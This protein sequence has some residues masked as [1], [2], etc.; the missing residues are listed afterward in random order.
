MDHIIEVPGDDSVSRDLARSS[1]DIDDNVLI[2]ENVSRKKKAMDE[3]MLDLSAMMEALPS[4]RPLY[5]SYFEVIDGDQKDGELLLRPVEE[6]RYPIVFT[7]ITKYLKWT[8]PTPYGVKSAD[9]DVVLGISAKSMNL[10][11]IEA[12]VITVFHNNGDS[13]AAKSE[14][15]TSQEL[16]RLCLAA[17]TSGA[18]N[19][20]SDD[21]CFRW[22]LH[23]KLLLL[24]RKEEVE[25][26]D[27]STMIVMEVKTWL[28][29]L[30]DYGSIEFH[31]VEIISDLKALGNSDPM[32]KEHRPFI[33][34]ADINRTGVSPLDRTA[35]GLMRITDYTISRDETRVLVAAVAG[36]SQFLQLW[37]FPQ[38]RQQQLVAWMQFRM[39]NK[40]AYDYCLSWSGSQLVC[41]DLNGLN[42]GSNKE[43]TTAF[44]KVDISHTMAPD[45]AIAGSGF[46]SFTPD[47]KDCPKLKDL[48]AKAAFHI[49][50]T[51]IFNHD[52]LFVTCD[53]VTIEMYSTQNSWK[54]LRSIVIGPTR[55]APTP[56]NNV[57]NALRNNLR[58]SYLAMRDH[59]THQASTWDIGRG[60]RSSSYTNLTYEQMENVN[61]CAAVSK[62]GSRIAITGKYK[63]DIFL[64]K[65]WTLVANYPF[66]GMEYHPF[67]RSVQ[68]IDNE[69]IMV[70]LD[71]QHLPLYKQNRGLVLSANRVSKVEEYITEGRDTFRTTS[72][73]S[74]AIC[75]GVSQVSLFN[76]EDRIVL[77]PRRLKKR[78]GE[79]CR[80]IESFLGAG[81]SEPTAPSGLGFKAEYSTAPIDIHGRHEDLPVLVVT[82]K[83]GND[84]RRLSISL[85]KVLGFKSASFVNEGSHLLISFS[86]LVM[87]WS[88]PSSPQDTFTLQL[89]H[90][91]PNPSEWKVCSH[92]QLYGLRSEDQTV[93]DGINLNDPVFSM[94]DNFMDGITQLPLIFSNSN[95]VVQQEIIHYIGK[96]VNNSHCDVVRHVC[97]K[98]VEHTHISTVQLWKAVLAHPI[99]RWIPKPD[100]DRGTNPLV[101]ILENSVGNLQA[102][103]LAE[104]FIEYCVH[105]VK[106]EKDPLFLLPILQCLHELADPK[107]PHYD[108]AL[109]LLRDLAYLPARDR[110]LIMSRHSIAH[111]F[112]LRLRFWEPNSK[113][114][115]QYKD[116]VLQV[117]SASTVKCPENTFSREIYLASSEMLWQGSDVNEDLARKIKRVDIALF[118][119][120]LDVGLYHLSS[121][122]LPSED[123]HEVIRSGGTLLFDETTD[124]IEDI[125]M[126]WINFIVG[127]LGFF[128][129]IIYFIIYAV[130]VT[131]LF[132]F[133]RS[134][135]ACIVLMMDRFGMA[136]FPRVKCHHFE[137]EALNNPAIAAL[138]EYKW[139]TIGLQYWLFRFLAQCIYYALV[140]AGIFMQIYHNNDESTMRSIFAAI[141]ALAAWFLWLELLQIIN[142]KHGYFRSVYNYVDLLAFLTPFV[143]SILQ[144][145]S[146]DF[147]AQNSL[148]SFSALFIFLH[149]S[150]RYDPVSNGLS[151]DDV[152]IHIMLMMFFFFTVIVMMNV[153][154]AL[155]NHA[156]DDGE[157]TWELDW[158]QNRMRFVESAQNMSYV[159]EEQGEVDAN[160]GDSKT[161]TEKFEQLQKKQ[162]ETL[163]EQQEAYKVLLA[164]YEEQKRELALFKGEQQQ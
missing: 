145:N 97:S 10:D 164:A 4:P 64:T 158:L 116:Q 7:A 52:Q 73:S 140:I 93:T 36:D 34:T 47:E 95:H 137:F 60:I 127:V 132:I 124:L 25:K 100:M 91:V 44:Y 118:Q 159:L 121:L 5:R 9:Y 22:K 111:P 35:D 136:L 2:L 53:G 155:I 87:V 69:E 3:E 23:E 92:R 49:V 110:E 33:H 83:D 138:V 149:F 55:D 125:D 50:D 107:K 41:V 6:T 134:S 104:V 21:G 70:A 29:E 123:L 99:V 74:Q 148:L 161:M 40:P 133:Y 146:A 76:L 28:G 75:I 117:T 153:L 89:V 120:A 72:T 32:Y 122:F 80:S 106:L 68:F 94:E 147:G 103:K 90:A 131:I 12:I 102:F 151:N 141:V 27:K 115:D 14:V 62:D 19:V 58:G 38:K 82:F 112:E 63:V 57:G 96:N 81:F 109:K 105:Q 156:F 26:E 43:N 85:P 13:R 46:T 86:E 66:R 162:L 84:Q 160:A 129:G 45:K 78:C 88:G 150:G 128:S 130:I 30:A 37:Q 16:T 24:A 18:I 42:G 31:Y 142:Y 48:S 157:K 163:L 144:L 15:I 101:H 20:V 11:A 8:I 54:H 108:A 1:G 61:N 79:S 67:V 51:S 71:Y 126:R 119:F 152:A 139:N 17:Q 114:L 59:D 39:V 98:W 65:T 56:I 135:R 77:S 154:I 113:G 143:A